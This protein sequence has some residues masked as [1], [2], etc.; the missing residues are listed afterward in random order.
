MH[1]QKKRTSVR[2]TR[3]ERYRDS[4]VRNFRSN[5]IGFDLLYE[6]MIEKMEAEGFLPHKGYFVNGRKCPKTTD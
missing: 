4:L 1:L 2:T 5:G 6:G 3:G